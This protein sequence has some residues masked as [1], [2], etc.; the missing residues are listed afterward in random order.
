M[1]IC[2]NAPLCDHELPDGSKHTECHRC[3]A[4]VKRWLGRPKKDAQE[5]MTAVARYNVLLGVFAEHGKRIKTVE[6]HEQRIVEPNNK[7]REI[8]VA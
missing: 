6:H 5:R 2:I 1:R 4:Y 3:R 7:R 8:R